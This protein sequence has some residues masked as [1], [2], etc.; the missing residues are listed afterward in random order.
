V[1]LLV[2]VLLAAVFGCIFLG[3]W[4]SAAARARK[5][6]QKMEMM[7]KLHDQAL[8]EQAGREARGEAP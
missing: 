8:D 7:N 6:R 4:V 3:L 1:S 5:Q 2:G